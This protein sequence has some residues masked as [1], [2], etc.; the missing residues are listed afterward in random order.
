[1]GAG[2]ELEGFWGFWG[3]V[4]MGWN[5]LEWVGI[6]G[7][8][9]ARFWGGVWYNGR[10]DPGRLEH[11]LEAGKG[12]LGPSAKAGGFLVGRTE[13][14]GPSAPENG[15]WIALEGGGVSIWRTARGLRGG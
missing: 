4:G 9:L 12:W 14:G 7:K 8:I 3:I 6:F 15:G 11:G 13:N 1:M 10:V 2:R 5:G